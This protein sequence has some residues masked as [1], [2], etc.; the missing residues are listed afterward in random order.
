MIVMIA[1]VGMIASALTV[2][3]FKKNIEDYRKA[4]GMG[5]KWI[6]VIKDLIDNDTLIIIGLFAVLFI[7]SES[8]PKE[9]WA[10]IIGGVLA[11]LK[12]KK[13]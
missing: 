12:T 11:T 6:D 9:A 13:G 8:M 2:D 10:L 1:Q 4:I 5:K 3:K 7:G